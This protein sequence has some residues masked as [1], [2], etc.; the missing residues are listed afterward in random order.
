MGSPLNSFS[1]IC[2]SCAAK[3]KVTKA[4]AVG[5]LLA[6]PKCGMMIKVAPPK[7]WVPPASASQDSLENPLPDSVSGFDSRFDFDDVDHLLAKPDQVTSAH[8]SSHAPTTHSQGSKFRG[9]DAVPETAVPKQRANVS[10]PLL[11]N[12]NWESE[13]SK[14]NK[15]WLRILAAV[16]GLIV[17]GG[18]IFAMMSSNRDQPP[19]NVSKKLE[20]ANNV[21]PNDSDPVTSETVESG[22]VTESNSKE[23]ETQAAITDSDSNRSSDPPTADPDPDP[24]ASATDSPTALPPPP[25]PNDHSVG[26][27]AKQETAQPETQDSN[28]ESLLPL[29]PFRNSETATLSATATTPKSESTQTGVGMVNKIEKQMGDLAGLLEQS[30][31]SL[32]ELSDA[33]VKASGTSLAG[34]PKYVIEKP[35]PAKSNSERLNLNVGGLLFDQTPLPVVVRELSSLSG[36]PITIDA[37][38][39]EAA[40]KEINQQISATIKDADLNTAMD[41]LLAPLGITKKTDSVGLQFTVTNSQDF[42]KASHSTAQFSGL[43]EQARKSFLAHIQGLIDPEIWGRAQDPAE[44]ELQGEDIVAQCPAEV[45]TQIKRLISKLMAANVLIAAPTDPAAIDQTLTRSAAIASKLE[46]AIETEHTIRT[47]IGLFLTKLHSKSNVTVVADWEN[48]AKQGWNP[49]TLIPGNIDEPTAGEV[50][51]QLAQ[52]MNL[53][54]VVIDASTLMLTTVERAAITRDIEVY[55]V[56]KLLAGKFDEAQLKEAFHATLGFELRNEKYVYDSSCQ[57]FIVAASQ[58]KQRQVEALLN[59]LEGI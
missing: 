31:A 9:S 33:T 15:T 47:P 51:R 3:L 21:Q 46:A 19:K 44:I 26:P 5:Q 6:C 48:L 10:Q 13:R 17:L 43:D 12:Q 58:A 25:L 59:R 40:G 36:V 56:A 32:N 34:I 29:S 45:H 35:D 16:L 14:G 55:P 37:R 41:Q 50:V 2:R 30:G 20:E 27:L 8:Q 39:L 1:I 22:T 4:S 28:P 42:K 38:S 54:V 11:P 23:P 24:D 57:C 49:Q 53:S 7:D 18:F 52:S